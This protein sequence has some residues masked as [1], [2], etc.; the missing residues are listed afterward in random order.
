MKI[1]K[2]Y[3]SLQHFG[4]ISGTLPAEMNTLDTLNSQFRPFKIFQNL[5]VDPL[6]EELDGAFHMTWYG[7][8][9]SIFLAFSALDVGFM[10]PSIRYFLTKLLVDCSWYLGFLLKGA[11]T[12]LEGMIF[13]GD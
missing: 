10:C 6:P 1:D 8:T 4:E 3:V 12:F 13:Y 11:P 5:R 2:I 7:G 9:V